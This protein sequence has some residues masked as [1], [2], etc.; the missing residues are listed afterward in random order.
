MRRKV[1]SLPSCACELDGEAP[2]EPEPGV[3]GVTDDWKYSALP[4]QPRGLGFSM[5][6]GL[7]TPAEDQRTR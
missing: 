4:T 6:V 5:G 7:V 3:R 1:S 2:S